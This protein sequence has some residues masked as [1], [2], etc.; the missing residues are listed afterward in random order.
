[1]LLACWRQLLPLHHCRVP[2]RLSPRRLISIS[3]ATMA[4][5]KGTTMILDGLRKAMKDRRFTAEPLAAYIIPSC[6]AHNSEYLAECDERRQYVS[7]FTGSAGTA[8]VTPKQVP[9][10]S[11]CQMNNH[12]EGTDVDRWPLPPAGEQGDGWKLD[13]DEGQA[14]II[15]LQRSW[16]SLVIRCQII[17]KFDN[18]GIS[19]MACIQAVAKMKC[20]TGSLKLPAKL[21]GLPPPSHP[22]VLV[23]TR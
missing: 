7:G 18:S 17:F 5:P 9:P 11:Q 12:F 14:A 4:P 3:V 21:T 16:I 1:M 20:R 6:D 15:L 2:Q 8:I 10:V 23:S 22:A 19:L 13:F